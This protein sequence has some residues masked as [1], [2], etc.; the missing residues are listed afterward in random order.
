NGHAIRHP[1]GTTRR[2]PPFLLRNQGGKFK[3]I[4]ARGGSYFRADHLARGAALGDLDNDGKVDLVVSHMN[5]PVAVLRNV[6][7]GGNHWLGVQLV[8]RGNAD[9]VGARVVLEAGGRTQ[10]RF[11]RSGGSYASSPD[12][13]LVF[14]VG[15]ADRVE[16]LAVSWPDGTRHE[17]TGLALDRYH[18]L[19]QGEP[20]P[21]ASRPRK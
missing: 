2:E 11:A 21:R 20:E 8:G 6:A 9:V 17:W 14:G 1:S 4:T 10:T 12:R 16:R 5:E 7:A 3:D 18:V 13:R 15:K 19:V